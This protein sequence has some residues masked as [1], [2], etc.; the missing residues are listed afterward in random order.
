M[1][2]AIRTKWPRQTLTVCLTFSQAKT[3]AHNST[4]I[5]IFV[6]GTYTATTD[7]TA[8]TPQKQTGS[9]DA[10]PG[11]SRADRQVWAT[12]HRRALISPTRSIVEMDP[13]EA[14]SPG[15]ECVCTICARLL[16]CA[17]SS[18]T[19]TVPPPATDP[20]DEPESRAQR[21]QELDMIPR[22][23]ATRHPCDSSLDRPR[24]LGVGDVK[25][26]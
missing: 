19:F 20:G 3:D 16:V 14:G 17:P 6:C 8:V 23:V 13:T 18:Q 25:G 4:R 2:I 9:T 21:S 22:L 7:C 24:R 1:S 10:G 12:D 15:S 5:V 11:A 26:S